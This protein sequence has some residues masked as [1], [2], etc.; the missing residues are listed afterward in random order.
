MPRLTELRPTSRRECRRSMSLV[1]LQETATN[2]RVS[3]PS[4]ARGSRRS[5]QFLSSPG[6]CAP[7]ERP[8]AE[9]PVVCELR[10]AAQQNP[11]LL[12]HDL[13]HLADRD[14]EQPSS[15]QPCP[16]LKQLRLG[17]GA[18]ADPR[19]MANPAMMQR[20]LIATAPL[21]VAL[22]LGLS[23]VLVTTSS[24]AGSRGVQS[25][26]LRETLGRPGIYS[27]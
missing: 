26:R 24:S 22:S 3:A 27:A 18:E 1:G 5:C 10:W 20:S 9:S 6:S 19:D 13:V 2:H 7:R 12:W 11:L 15:E 23:G 14:Q 17:R 25:S 8:L 21:S 4:S 16:H